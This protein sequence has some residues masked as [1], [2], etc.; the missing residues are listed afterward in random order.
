MA[1]F[2]A[3]F[4]AGINGNTITTAP[5]EASL[6]AWDEIFILTTLTYDNDPVAHGALSARLEGSGTRMTWNLPTPTDHYGR[7][8]LYV[9]STALDFTFVIVDNPAF[10]GVV[11]I[12]CVSGK[13]RVSDSVAATT[14]GT[15]NIAT[16]QW[17][18]IEYHVIHSA[19]V[20]QIEAKL[21]NNAES[22]TPSDTITSPANRNTSTQAFDVR[23]LISGIAGP[24]NM[25]SIVA[26]AIS[27]PGPAVAPSIVNF[28]PVI[29]GRG[30]C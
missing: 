11:S 4:E 2:T 15:V 26:N 30:A 19:T 21:F 14:D 12:S 6:T 22:S 5:G 1:D 13:I 23:F 20:G 24:I 9:T 10:T 3:M 28:A 18:R 25:D 16:N 27:Y 29:Y 8:Y 17:V 7:V